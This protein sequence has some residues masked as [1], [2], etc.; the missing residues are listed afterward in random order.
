[1]WA[2]QDEILAGKLS[3][4]EN[5]LDNT[6][7]FWG[8]VNDFKHCTDTDSSHSDV[9]T[10]SMNLQIRYLMRCVPEDDIWKS[11]R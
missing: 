2:V 7:K 4:W 10:M 8:Y 6:L 11:L 9:G 3:N 5:A 1:M